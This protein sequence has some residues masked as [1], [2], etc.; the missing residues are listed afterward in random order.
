MPNLRV[1]EFVEPDGVGCCCDMAEWEIIDKGDF[2]YTSCVT[3]ACSAHLAG[4]IGHHASLPVGVTDCWEL[5]PVV[6]SD[7]CLLTTTK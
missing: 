7:R 3:L 5:R 1:C 4:L 6:R 2:D